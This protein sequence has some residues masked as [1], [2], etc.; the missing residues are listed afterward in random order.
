MCSQNH[1]TFSFFNILTVLGG[2]YLFFTIQLLGRKEIKLTCFSQNSWALINAATS[3]DTDMFLSKSLKGTCFVLL[4]APHR[5]WLQSRQK[6]LI[7][8]CCKLKCL[9]SCSFSI[10]HVLEVLRIMSGNTTF[11]FPTCLPV[12]NLKWWF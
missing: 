2:P 10:I 6:L 5:A 4:Y 3:K 8:W 11:C 12:P 1:N 7:Y 9:G